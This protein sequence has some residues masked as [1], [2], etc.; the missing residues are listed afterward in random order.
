MDQYE[1]ILNGVVHLTVRPYDTERLSDDDQPLSCAWPG[2]A[3]QRC[4]YHDN[5]WFS[6]PQWNNQIGCYFFSNAV[7]AAVELE[8]G[9]LEDRTLQRAESLGFPGH[10]PSSSDPTVAAQWNYLFQQAGHVHLFRE[11]V[12]IPNVDTSAYQ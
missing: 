11:R 10:P 8:L 1:P 4:D 6:P 2:R 9:V 5:V 12:T 3:Q 7:P